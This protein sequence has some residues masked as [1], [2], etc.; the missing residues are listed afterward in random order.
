MRRLSLF[1]LFLALSSSRLAAQQERAGHVMGDLDQFTGAYTQRVPIDVPAFHGLEPRLALQYHSAAGNGW[2]GVGWSLTG[3]DYVERAHPSTFDQAT[4]GGDRLVPCATGSLSPS[5]TSAIAAFGSSAGFYSTHIESFRR[6]QYDA[7]GDRWIVWETD[8]T[9]SV[10]GGTAHVFKLDTTAAAPVFRWLLATRTDTHNNVVDYD[11]ECTPNAS[12]GHADCF[13]SQIRYGNAVI[14]F[15]EQ[16]RHDVVSTG[17]SSVGTTDD[18]IFGRMTTRLRRI[19]V[20]ANDGAIFR[21]A[22]VYDLKYDETAMSPNPGSGSATVRS[23]LT[24][25]KEYGKDATILGDEISGSASSFPTLGFDYTGRTPTSLAPVWSTGPSLPYYCDTQVPVVVADWDGNRCDDFTVFDG[26]DDVSVWFSNCNG[27]FSFSKVANLGY[28][29]INPSRRRLGD[30]NGDGRTDLLLISSFNDAQPLRLFLSGRD[31][32]TGQLTFTYQAGPTFLVTVNQSTTRIEEIDYGRLETGDFNADGLTDLAIASG[33]HHPQTTTVCDTATPIRILLTQKSGPTL[34]WNEVPG[35]LLTIGPSLIGDMLYDVRRP[36]YADFNGDGRTDISITQGQDTTWANAVPTDL[37]YSRIGVPGAPS[38]FQSFTGTGPKLAYRTLSYYNGGGINDDTRIRF[39]DFNGDG[40]A[41]LVYVEGSSGGSG[42]TKIWL[43][44]GSGGRFGSEITGPTQW[45]SGFYTPFS[46]GMVPLADFN[47]DGRTDVGHLN[48]NALEVR[49]SIGYDAATVSFSQAIPGYGQYVVDCTQVGDFD[50]D[51]RAD[52]AD[53]S[54]GTSP[55]IHRATGTA[56]DLLSR[57]DNGIGGVSTI[58]YAPS[59]G[60]KNDP[61]APIVQVVTQTTV[62]DGAGGSATTDTSYEG[63]K[64]DA[65][66]RRF[67]GFY[68]VTEALPLTPSDNNVRVHKRTTFIQDARTMANLEDIVEIFKG[69]PTSGG[70]VMKSTDVDYRIGAPY[71]APCSG[72]PPYVTLPTRTETRVMDESGLGC[73]SNWPI[74][75]TCLHGNRTVVDRE[76]DLMASGTCGATGLPAWKTG[77]GNVTK[78]LLHGNYD[79]PDDAERQ[80]DTTFPTVPNVSGYVV[81]KPVSQRVRQGVSGQGSILKQENYFYDMSLPAN[82]DGSTGWDLAVAKGDPTSIA[83][84]LNLPT[85]RYVVSRAEFDTAGN[86]TATIDELGNRDVTVYDTGYKLFPTLRRN[87]VLHEWRPTYDFVCGVLKSEIDPN[88]N[89]T[90]HTLDNLCRRTRSDFPGGG[91][92]TVSYSLGTT[93]TSRYTRKAGPG[94]NAGDLYAYT[95]FD[96]LGRTTKTVGRGPSAAQDIVTTTA[97]DARGRVASAVAA[98]YANAAPPLA[99]TMRY[100]AL[101]REVQVSLPDNRNRYFAHGYES[102][103]YRVLLTDEENKQKKTYYDGFGDI[104]ELRQLKVGSTWIAS[105]FVNRLDMT[106]AID[107]AGNHWTKLLDSLGRVYEERHPDK[108]TWNYEYWDTGWLKQTADNSTPRKLTYYEYDGIGRKHYKASQYGSLYE[109]WISWEYDWAEAGYANIGR[110]SY[111][112]DNAGDETYSWDAAGNLA[113]RQRYIGASPQ[114]FQFGYDTG[115]RLR[116]KTYPDGDTYGT[117]SSPLQYDDAGRLSYGPGVFSSVAYTAWGA[118]SSYNNGNGIVSTRSYDPARQW[119]TGI[120][121]T[122]SFQ[123]TCETMSISGHQCIIDWCGDQIYCGPGTFQCCQTPPPEDIQD[124]AYTRD[125][126]GRVTQVTSPFGNEGWAF[127]FDNLGRLTQANSLT[128]SYYDQSWTYDDSGNIL[129]NSAVGAYTY[130]APKPGGGVLPHAVSNAGGTGYTYDANGNMN[131]GRLGTMVWDGDGMPSK[132]GAL[133]FLYDGNGRRLR[134]YRIGNL[135]TLTWYVDNDYELNQNVAT[136]YFR[137]GDLL[138]AKR[139]AGVTYWLHTDDLGSVQAITD[140]T[141]TTVWRQQYHPYGEAFVAG[142]PHQESHAFTGERRDENGL[143]YLAARYYDPVLGRFIS[144]DDRIGAEGIVGLNPYVYAANDPVNNTDHSGHFV[145]TAFDIAMAVVSVKQ[146]VA[147]PNFLNIAG[148]VLD[149]GAVIV[150]GAPAVGGRLLDAVQA[151]NKIVD[152]AQAGSKLAKES[153]AASRLVET[154]AESRKTREIVVDAA[155]HPESAK[156]IK[157]AQAAGKPEVLTIDR[158][159]AKERRAQATR[160]TPTQPGKDR[161]EYPPAMTK[162]GGQGASVRPVS[163]ADN[164][165]AGACIGNQCR[166]M[167]DG[168]KIRIRVREP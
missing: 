54:V 83:R 8:G 152:V 9:K 136:K 2:V 10:Y 108:G 15:E 1:A 71:G 44:T 13:P 57:S 52:V 64:Y 100:D 122:R 61:G 147:E 66:S 159:G 87:A 162:E 72:N 14:E 39:G 146:A 121:T 167:P 132:I 99:T 38:N 55:R 168:T 65:P 154:A 98:Y 161:D 19:W 153:K 116:W 142:Y 45:L 96:G 48:S 135:S 117:P 43:S 149:V 94:A 104:S 106:D 7:L 70:F 40:F 11:W 30:F 26:L 36:K 50:G 131:G 82:G 151:G 24:S 85:S 88:G 42:P 69:S 28:G 58:A 124:L 126:L 75:T 89:T 166:N 32:V 105:Q 23:V 160:D 125:G 25:V 141:G 4:L 148:A 62:Q 114:L 76:Y 68:R 49:P 79:L 120:R 29:T 37:H 34:T 17:K 67:L 90:T 164:R 78:E 157:D 59:T 128:N 31:P 101:D 165:G 56:P 119:L 91:F 35:P 130:N 140:G 3:V 163:S 118:V 84:W 97:Y 144:S 115:N 102:G 133:S 77:Y 107:P 5:C 138:V 93:A 134:S 16:P 127:G 139:K 110:L 27:T 41:D 123:M 63:A 47:G 86:R 95:Y 80:V 137:L 103:R 143:I 21:L 92:E 109:T 113:K 20:R 18:A 150:P 81:D 12:G 145:E 155:K 51:G 22:R 156:H 158:A 53:T 73:S 6:I 46:A 74:G 33:C 112:Y 60:S 111:M 129:T